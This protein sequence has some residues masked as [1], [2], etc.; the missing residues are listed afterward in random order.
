MIE[1]KEKIEKALLKRLDN[2]NLDQ[3]IEWYEAS[4]KLRSGIDEKRN[5]RK[6]LSKKISEEIKSGKDA[7]GLKE[8]VRICGDEIS[9]NE[10]SLKEYE[11]KIKNFLEYLPNVPEDIVPAGG[12]ENNEVLEVIGNKPE[13][14]FKFRDHMELSASLGL[15]D[16]ER[17]VKLGGT[18]KWVYTNNGALME[19]ALINFFIQEHV[20]NNY[21]FIIPPH[22]LKVECGFVAGQ[23]PK[24]TDDVFYIKSDNDNAP[25]HFLLPTAETAIAN[26][27]SDELLAEKELPIKI[28]AYTPCYRKEAGS[29]RTKERGTIRGNQ[30]NKVEVFQI[31]TPEDSENRFQEI[32][33]RVKSLMNKLGLHYRL[34]RLAAKDCSEGMAKTYDVEV[35]IPSINDYKEV[36]SISTAHTFQSVR[37]KIR[38][39]CKDSGKNRYVHTLNGS[40]LATSRL[41]PAILEQ[42][43]QEDGS[44]L[45]PEVL[46]HFIGQDKLKP[47]VL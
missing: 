15:V 5:K 4:C 1:D 41:F 20:K 28:C 31:T 12:K 38:Y 29:Y 13:F 2:I 14:S 18:G 30:F 44:V 21:Q 47:P 26:L 17:G 34:T 6:E 9:S 23:F 8:E 33:T 42:F 36:S 19:W 24:F 39:K 16:H 35:W 37:G 10:F 40:G 32:V 45:I 22:I 7:S 11:A 25:T 43:Q 46:R 27:Y 3:V